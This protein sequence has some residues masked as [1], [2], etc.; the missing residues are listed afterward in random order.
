MAE[1]VGHGGEKTDEVD[2]IGELSHDLLQYSKLRVPS[3]NTVLAKTMGGKG[4][5]VG[6]LLVHFARIL[7]E[8]IDRVTLVYSP[9]QTADYDHLMGR[10]SVELVSCAAV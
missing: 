10:L 3:I 4:I 9:E 6:E 2:E 1:G 5:L 8:P 7:A